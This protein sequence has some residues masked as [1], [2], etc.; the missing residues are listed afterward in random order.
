MTSYR[1][2]LIGSI[3]W[4]IKLYNAASLSK[5]LVVTS[6]M[7]FALGNYSKHHESKSALVIVCPN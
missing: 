5:L 6:N 1:L 3:F 4:V 2:N 7:I